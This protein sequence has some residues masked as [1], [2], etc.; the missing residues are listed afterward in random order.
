MKI[1]R[2]TFFA[3]SLLLGLGTTTVFGS[4]PN[5]HKENECLADEDNICV[6]KPSPAD[7]LNTY[8][9]LIPKVRG[10][11]LSKI[12]VML[13][14]I[15]RRYRDIL[16][17]LKEK[18]SLLEKEIDKSKKTTTQNL[19]RLLDAGEK[20]TRFINSS[21]NN[22]SANVL[23]FAVINDQIQKNVDDLLPKGENTLS[24]KASEL[25]N[26]IVKIIKDSSQI[27]KEIETE[28]RK[29]NKNVESLNDNIE[30]INKLVE[31]ATRHIDTA[32]HSKSTQSQIAE[33]KSITKKDVNEIIKIVER[34]L[35]P[36]A[37]NIEKALDMIETLI[38]ALR[39]VHSWVITIDQD[40]PFQEKS[41]NQ[42]TQFI[43]TNFSGLYI[44][45]RKDLPRRMLI[46]ISRAIEETCGRVTMLEQAHIVTNYVE[47]VGRQ[48]YSD[49][50]SCNRE[51]IFRRILRLIKNGL[52]YLD[53][54]LD[55]I[56][57]CESE[58]A[59]R[60]LAS[61]LTDI[62]MKYYCR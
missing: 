16:D 4:S 39:G 35:K 62:I 25:V 48:I 37:S 7:A 32:N 9:L 22:S 13:T 55:K 27:Q 58:T 57:R 42:N 14:T 28:Q 11:I 38:L 46:E 50:V 26:D 61:K 33:A 12:V 51:E 49:V 60:N 34:E 52:G 36:L 10:E 40:I 8:I 23:A 44:T 47:L 18:V 41:K 20:Q 53:W 19:K 30:K 1:E 15:C 56:V 2:R 54:W 43:K 5:N 6:A 3:Q 17:E 31:S 21:T 59:K 45:N 29:V 24:P